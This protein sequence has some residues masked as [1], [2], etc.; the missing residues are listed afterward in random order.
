MSSS[1]SSGLL[2]MRRTAGVLVVATVA[3]VLAPFPASAEVVTTPTI[4]APAEGATIVSS[5]MLVSAD[6]GAAYVRFVVAGQIMQTVPV[7]T[8]SAV[9]EIPVPGLDGNTWIDAYDCDTETSC[10]DTPVS[11]T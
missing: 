6:S 5:P 8:G 4:T 3:A 9:T 2:P 11:I 7:S 10:A 1:V